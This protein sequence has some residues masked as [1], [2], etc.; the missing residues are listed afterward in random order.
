MRKSID[1]TITADGRDKGKTYRITEMSATAAE[2]WAL[3]AINGAVRAGVEVPDGLQGI[4]MAALAMLGAKAFA[5]MAWFDLKPLLDEMMACVQFVAEKGVHPI[6]DGDIEEAA[7]RLQLRK[8]IIEL[9]TG[10][11]SRAGAS[12]STS[13]A[14]PAPESTDS[15]KS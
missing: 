8:E 9:H 1:I 6:Y 15:S 2:E 13:S 7:T 14:A 10:F 5:G 11:F 12:T 4:G 3:R